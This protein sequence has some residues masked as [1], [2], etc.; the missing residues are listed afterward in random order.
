MPASRM[1]SISDAPTLMGKRCTS[2]CRVVTTTSLISQ[3]LSR[4]FSKH[5]SSHW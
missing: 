4:S 2:P 3:T 1:I 5:Y